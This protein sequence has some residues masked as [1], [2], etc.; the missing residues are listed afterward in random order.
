MYVCDEEIETAWG[1]LHAQHMSPS[2]VPL[3]GKN[4]ARAAIF[5]RPSNQR[6][7]RLSVRVPACVSNVCAHA[8]LWQC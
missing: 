1:A 6:R 4:I 2:L 7:R 3:P 8:P 5:L